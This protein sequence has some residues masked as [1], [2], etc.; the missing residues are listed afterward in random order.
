MRGDT[1]E[2]GFRLKFKLNKTRGAASGPAAAAAGG[3]EVSPLLRC[4][5]AIFS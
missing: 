3:L 2:S 1:G 4:L 5:F